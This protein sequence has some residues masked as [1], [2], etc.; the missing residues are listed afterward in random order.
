MILNK[1]HTHYVW[2]TITASSIQIQIP[3]KL[4]NLKD[5]ERL[6]WAGRKKYQSYSNFLTAMLN[7]KKQHS[8]NSKIKNKQTA[9]ATTKT[10]T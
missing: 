1:K 4:S 10:M 2:E 5:K 9:E 7:T 6:H 8:Y 3:V